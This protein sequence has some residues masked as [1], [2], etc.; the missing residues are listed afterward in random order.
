MKKKIAIVVQRYG[1]EVNGGSEYSSRLIAEKLSKNYDVDV[2]TTKA[3]DYMTWE[4]HYDYDNE[5]I[6]GVNVLRFSVERPRNVQQ[7]N[8]L[9]EQ[10]FPNNNRTYNEELNWIEQQG[11]YCLQII[12]Y[13]KLNS[14]K[15]HKFIFFTYAYYPTFIGLQIVPEKSIFVP[16][17]HDETQIYFTPYKKLFHLPR[18]IIYLTEEEKVFVNKKFKNEYVQS[19]VAGIG[20]EVPEQYI[21][22]KEFRDK[23]KV[24]DKF[25]LYI[26]RID[27]SKGCKEMFNYFLENQQ[28]YRGNV[29]LLLIGKP[30][31]EIPKHNNI[32]ELGFV[33]EKDKFGAILASEALIMPSKFESLSMVVL[34]SLYMKRP[35]IVNEECEVLKGHCYRS[36]AGLYFKNSLEFFETTSLILNNEALKQKLG[37]N[38]AKYVKEYFDWTSIMKKFDKAIND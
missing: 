19:S 30:M 12:Q 6:N 36:N 34:E 7:F 29:K 5:M 32:I 18:H 9:S 10:L 27:E 24:S 25:L 14:E 38:G 15:Y 26:G 23:Y 1:L 2:L 28:N 13:I 33:S 8:K 31:M 16:T 4:D 21:N 3:I 17:A 37:E 35:V 22:E 20:V 11:P